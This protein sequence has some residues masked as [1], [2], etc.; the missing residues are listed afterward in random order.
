MIASVYIKDGNICF[1]NENKEFTDLGGIAYELGRPLLDFVCYKPERFD[2]GFNSIAAAF[3]NEYAHVGAKE[4]EFISEIKQM[5]NEAQQKEIYLFFYYQMLLKFIYAFIDSP[6]EAVTRLAEKIPT[7]EEKLR[8][9]MDFEW[10]VPPQG[11]V[12]ADKEKQL[13]RAVMDVVALM[14]DHICRFQKFIIHEIEV[15]LH[16]RRD[17]EVPTGRSIDY[18]DILDEY[19]SAKNIGNYYLE[20]PFMTFYGRTATLEVVQ[21]YVIDKIDDLFRYEFVQMIEY[22]IFIKKCKNCECFFIPERRVDAEYCNRIYGGNN[23]R[24]NEIGAMLRYERKVAENPVWEAYKKAYRRLNS[25]T[26]NKKMTQTEFLT[27]SEEA[28]KKRGE[29]LAGALSFEE[30][31]EWLEQGRIRR[32]RSRNSKR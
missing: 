8:W 14:S 27:W 3:D 13:F 11:K 32:S 31:V 4:P 5:M 26:R 16:Y 28:G 23:R 12:Y 18:I 21:L 30:Y 17:I 1:Y 22:D 29:C 19:H 24:C 6:R 10:P 25:R 9:A 7:A 20:R 2:D 15:L